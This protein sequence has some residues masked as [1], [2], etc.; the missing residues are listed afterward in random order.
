MKILTT[1][2]CENI[3]SVVHNVLKV[4]FVCFLSSWIKHMAGGQLTERLHWTKKKRAAEHLLHLLLLRLKFLSGVVSSRSFFDSF[5]SLGCA[6]CFTRLT[7]LFCTAPQARRGCR[8][9]TYLLPVRADC[10]QFNNHPF[11]FLIF[12]FS[13]F[14]NG[15]KECAAFQTRI[16]AV[17]NCR[18]SSLLGK[19][20]DSTWLLKWCVRVICLS[21]CDNFMLGHNSESPH[22]SE[23]WLQT[24][25]L[26]CSAGVHLFLFFL[27][28]FYLILIV[29]FG[30]SNGVCVVVVEGELSPCRNMN[31]G[32]G[33]L[34]LLT[35][36]GRVNC[37][38]RGER[39]L[40]DDNRCVCKSSAN[41]QITVQ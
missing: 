40:L 11:H 18:L 10:A 13:P 8:K 38:C 32:C 28:F 37:T 1:I 5:L 29:R 9:L 3:L 27:L 25:F 22:R 36:Q 15:R 4:F 2:Y 39:V 17:V 12:F 16:K 20:L 41:L 24:G 21:S 19:Q 34:C 6:F 30:P 35:P 23:Q 14:N 31:G 33:D 7:E 26:R